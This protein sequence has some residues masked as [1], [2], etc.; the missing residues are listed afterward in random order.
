MSVKLVHTHVKE[1]WE[2]RFNGVNYEIMLKLIH[3]DDLFGRPLNAEGR[4]KTS[5]MCRRIFVNTV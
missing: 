4:N 3:K 2:F 5:L 1:Q